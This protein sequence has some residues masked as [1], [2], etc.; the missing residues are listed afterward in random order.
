MYIAAVL[1][2]FSLSLSLSLSLSEQDR[3]AQPEAPDLT[4]VYVVAAGIVVLVILVIGG[5][6]GKR[7]RDNGGISPTLKRIRVNHTWQVPGGQTPE[8]T[9]PPQT[10]EPSLL[11]DR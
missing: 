3:P 6:L 7:V 1:A 4:P 8:P 9:T 10:R 11:S 2:S 5:L